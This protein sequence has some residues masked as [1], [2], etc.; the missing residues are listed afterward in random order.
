MLYST[1]GTSRLNWGA[2]K[3]SNTDMRMLGQDTASSF[4]FR[5][6]DGSATWTTLTAPSWP[7]SG[8]VTNSR[9]SL[10]SQGTYIFAFVIRGDASNTIAYAFYDGVVWSGW[11]DLTT[12]TKTRNYIE[13]NYVVQANQALVSWTETNGSNYDFKV[14]S[15]TAPELEALMRHGKAFGTNTVLPY[16]F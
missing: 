2:I 9:V 5:K 13:A 4:T 8:L 6:F 7:T 3:L 14:M 16:T 1:S 15:I 10:L 12:T 11:T